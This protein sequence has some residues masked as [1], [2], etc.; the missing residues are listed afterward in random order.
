LVKRLKRFEKNGF[1]VQAAERL[2]A[3]FVLVRGVFSSLYKPM[4]RAV[5]RCTQRRGIFFEKK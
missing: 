4:C 3:C 2:S 1:G 5:E